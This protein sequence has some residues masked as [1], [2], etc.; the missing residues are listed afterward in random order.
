MYLYFTKATRAVCY[1]TCQMLSAACL[2]TF[3]RP[4]YSIE[5]D[6]QHFFHN[7]DS[8]NS[9]TRCC[10][11]LYCR[12]DNPLSRIA[13]CQWEFANSFLIPQLTLRPPF[14]EAQDISLWEE[15]RCLILVSSYTFTFLLMCSI[16]L[17]NAVLALL[18]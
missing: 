11:I 4:L 8:L 6:C 12:T 15:K 1:E 14:S 13:L 5:S 2:S 18:F 16:A 10:R 7:C 17:P 9:S 3:W